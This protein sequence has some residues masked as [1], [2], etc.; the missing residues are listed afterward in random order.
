MIAC[1]GTARIVSARL[2]DRRERGRLAASRTSDRPWRPGCA[3]GG[4]GSRTRL[5]PAP[6]ASFRR[7]GVRGASCAIMPMWR[8]RG[9]LAGAASFVPAGSTNAASTNGQLTKISSSH[10]V[11]SRRYPS[12]RLGL[13]A[14]RAFTALSSAST[15]DDRA[16]N[17]R[18]AAMR[19]PART[20]T[21][22]RSAIVAA[23]V[24]PTPEH[25]VVVVL[26]NKI[27][28][29][30]GRSAGRA[31]YPARPRARRCCELR[32]ALEPPQDGRGPDAHPWP[33]STRCSPG[34]VSACGTRRCRSRH[35][36]P[37]PSSRRRSARAP[38]PSTREPDEM[39]EPQLSHVQCLVRQPA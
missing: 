38:T 37:R 16:S 9:V 22:H 23:V 18:S 31:P 12:P 10:E 7:A 36:A 39:R 15:Q 5:A 2:E 33:P 14:A 11:S 35:G 6:C 28:C 32:P 27:V 13:W 24:V 4:A 17:E 25:V 30:P 8:R 20:R 29:G 26:E 19:R 34:S 1:S 21:S 3:H